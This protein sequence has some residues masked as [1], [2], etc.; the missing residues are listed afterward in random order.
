MISLC[1][2][3]EVIEGVYD[4]FHW[5]FEGDDFVLRLPDGSYRFTVRGDHALVHT[6]MGLPD[7]L[8]QALV[9]RTS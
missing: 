9:P 3:L 6:G 4:D 8:W 7:A 2:L 5:G 1:D